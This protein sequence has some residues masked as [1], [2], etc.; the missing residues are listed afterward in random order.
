MFWCACVFGPVRG[1][2]YRCEVGAVMLGRGHGLF[3]LLFRGLGSPELLLPIFSVFLWFS[4]VWE[5]N[6]VCGF[7]MFG[8]SA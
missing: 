1:E 4:F 6:L 8:V 3:L 5:L 2:I 7:R